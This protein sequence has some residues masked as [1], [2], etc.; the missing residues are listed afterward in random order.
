MT[1]VLALRLALCAKG[2]VPL[3]LYGKTPPVY[4]KHGAKRGFANWQKI[5]TVT[6]E[7]I[8]I[9]AQTWPEA[10]NT[11]ILTKRAPALDADIL[12]EEAARAVEDLVRRRYEERGPILV[13]IGRPPKRAMLFRT[14]NPFAK[15]V[16]NVVAP[17]GSSERIE[18]LGEG[19]QITVA[20]VHPDTGKPYTWHGGDLTQTAHDELPSISE[21][22]ARALVHDIVGM[23]CREFDYTGAPATSATASGS[24][25]PASEWRKLVKG[26]GDGTRDCTIARLAGHLL[27]HHV[28]PFVA[29]ELLQ[30][31]NAARCAPP[32]PAADVVRIVNSIAGK[33]LKRRAAN[34]G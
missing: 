31:W 30:T 10:I 15:I 20:G 8:G 21:R 7:M 17:N 4:G 25:A 34:G 32:L 12:N 1:D 23:L 29:L 9:W 5:E 6:P 18:L 27:R 2:Y 16:G 11:G 28:D 3:P 33:E 24:A 13:R 22:E 19:Q 26:V 14:G